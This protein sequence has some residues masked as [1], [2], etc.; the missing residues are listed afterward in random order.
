MLVMLPASVAG[1]L[2]SV[3]IEADAGW[4]QALSRPLQA[5]AQPLLIASALLLGAGSVRCGWSPVTA[6]LA[7]GT[8]LYLGM[9]VVTGPGGQTQPALFYAGVALFL[10]SPILTLARP[11]LRACRPLFR[12]NAAGK[13]L[14][15]VLALSAIL[16]GVAPPLGWGRAA[17]APHAQHVTGGRQVPVRAA[18]P[19][20][21][22]IRVV[23]DAFL[24][25]GTVQD[26]TSSD[27][28]FPEIST[29][30]AVLRIRGEIRGGGVFVQLMD[31]R[32]AIVYEETFTATPAR[33]VEVT[34]PGARGV[35]MVTLG[36]EGLSGELEVEV[37]PA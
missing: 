21:P 35:W 16:I 11:R 13:V 17:G 31:G 7:G 14:L 10:A 19:A 32:A 12:G 8:M 9:Y 2:A 4:V 36:F 15:S 34:V 1:I 25:S 5:V 37:G 18:T 6:A 22:L 29:D 3:G 33:D 27:A 30:G 24:W 20:S 26:Y 23:E 28:W